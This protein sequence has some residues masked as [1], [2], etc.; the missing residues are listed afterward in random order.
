MRI[1]AITPPTATPPPSSSLP[2]PLPRRHLIHPGILSICLLQVFFICLWGPW[3]VLDFVFLGVLFET[4]TSCVRLTRLGLAAIPISASQIRYSGATPPHP[5]LFFFVD[6]LVWFGLAS[7]TFLFSILK[8]GERRGCKQFSG[9]NS[10]IKDREDQS[11]AVLSSPG[12]VC[13]P[14]PSPSRSLTSLGSPGKGT[15]GPRRYS[16]I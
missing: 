5:T 6:F 15:P 1:E 14:L 12:R 8:F 2:P 10:W 16:S 11:T 9:L 3:L 7:F 4:G 13:C